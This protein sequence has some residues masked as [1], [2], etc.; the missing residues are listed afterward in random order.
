M[1]AARSVRPAT[2]ATMASRCL[3]LRSSSHRA[4]AILNRSLNPA[5]PGMV[6]G[7]SRLRNCTEV[8]ARS[9]YPHTRDE[10][11][12]K[13]AAAQRRIE[14]LKCTAPAATAGGTNGWDK[15]PCFA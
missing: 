1:R 2:Q 10:L 9:G 13:V 12:E 11:R 7:E 4:C 3:V 15:P 14:A 6:P 8:V 5:M